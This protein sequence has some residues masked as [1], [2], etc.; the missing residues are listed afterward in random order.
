[1][2]NRQRVIAAIQ[3]QPVDRVPW[4]PLCSWSYFAGLREYQERFI[5]DGKERVKPEL[6]EEALA[7]RVAFHTE[8]IN[9]EFMQWCANSGIRKHYPKVRISETDAENTLRRCYQTPQGE[10]TQTSVWSETAHT[11]FPVEDLIKNEGNLAAFEYLIE[12]E[13]AEPDF[14]S[15]AQELAIVGENGVYFC[16]TPAPPLK[17]L[18]FGFMRLEYTAALLAEQR[19]R[20]E[21]LFARW[22]EKNLAI[23]Q[24][25]AKAPARIFM[26]AAVTGLGMVSPRWVREYYTPYS[27]AYQDILSQAGKLYVYHASGE[28]VLAIADSIAQEGAHLLYG[29]AWPPRGEAQFSHLRRALGPNI[30][31]SGGIE[32][33]FLSGADEKAVRARTREVLEDMVGQPGLLLGTA[34]DVSWDTPPELLAAVG[35]VARECA[36]LPAVSR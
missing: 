18:P 29:L 23:V 24:I 6:Q 12:D 2:T 8:R 17:Q 13:V 5:L 14:E 31:L 21:R 30:A 9:A 20:M 19:P 7:Y 28:P 32:P 25:Q 36:D 35:E 26:D 22:H 34:D 11:W 33:A 16:S 27:K 3:G 10:L 1:M 4:I 15:L